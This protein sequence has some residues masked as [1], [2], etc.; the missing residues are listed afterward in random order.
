M[1]F[2]LYL[3]PLTL[4]AQTL[5]ITVSPMSLAVTKHLLN[6]RIAKLV[7]P[8]LVTI[9]N[10]TDS[11]ISVSEAA[12]LRLLAPVGPFDHSAISILIDEA[13]R[14]SV[15]ARAG[16]GAGDVVKLGAFLAASN[17]VQWGPPI[18]MILSG[19]ISLAPYVIDRIRGAEA[20][21]RQ[22]FENLSWSAPITLQPAESGTGHVFTALWVP[23]SPSLTFQIDT[24]KILAIKV[25]Q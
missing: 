9:S 13:A 16:R 24:S 14:N 23:N 3:L 7:T 17:S 10:Q 18:P 15:L 8:C 2:I 11:A 5:T 25:I 1:R 6:A 21:I 20:P 19:T 12:V 22:N 4:S